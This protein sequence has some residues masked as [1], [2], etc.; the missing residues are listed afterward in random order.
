MRFDMEF[1]R[2]DTRASSVHSATDLG[3]LDLIR[4]CRER[5]ESLAR[6]ED[7]DTPRR[8]QLSSGTGSPGIERI[9]GVL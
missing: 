7:A 2:V 4:D 8:K 3:Q 9:I 5:L 1:V 6:L